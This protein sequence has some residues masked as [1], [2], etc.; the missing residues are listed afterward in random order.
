MKG[1]ERRFVAGQRDFLFFFRSRAVDQREAV[2]NR[3]ADWLEG[4]RAAL[5]EL[6][7]KFGFQK[8]HLGTLTPE[9]YFGDKAV[10]GYQVQPPRKLVPL[11]GT[12]FDSLPKR[13]CAQLGERY[14]PGE[15]RCRRVHRASPCRQESTF[16][17]RPDGTSKEISPARSSIAD[18]LRN[19]RTVLRTYAAILSMAQS[20]AE[21]VP[22][23][24]RAS[25]ATSA[26]SSPASPVS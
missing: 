16:G 9:F 10:E 14:E 1:L 22:K 15:F 25:A 5:L 18:W 3:P 19:P 17:T 8:D 2:G 26:E 13:S 20:G 4:Y 11:L 23:T 6:R 7:R 12:R 24:F 21:T